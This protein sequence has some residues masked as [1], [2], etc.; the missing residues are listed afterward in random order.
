MNFHL[1]SQEITDGLQVY[2]RPVV[3]STLVGIS[4]MF[5]FCSSF[6]TKLR[7]Y[8]VTKNTDHHFLSLNFKLDLEFD[9]LCLLIT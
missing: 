5:D 1:P 2:H 9:R 8:N 3:L 6:Y 7:L 4:V